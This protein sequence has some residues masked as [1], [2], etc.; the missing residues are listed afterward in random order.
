MTEGESSVLRRPYA[1]T[2]SPW[3]FISATAMPCPLHRFQ[4]GVGAPIFNPNTQEQRQVD[5]YAF[6]VELSPQSPEPARAT[7]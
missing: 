3:E 7:K 1:G 2:Y 4:P 5:L 6:R